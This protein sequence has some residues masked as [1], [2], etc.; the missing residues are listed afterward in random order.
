MKY[1]NLSNFVSL[2]V[3]FL[4]LSINSISAA[5]PNWIELDKLNK[6]T[7]HVFLPNQNVYFDLVTEH[8]IYVEN[9]SWVSSMNKPSFLEEIDLNREIKV[10]LRLKDNTKLYKNNSNHL[11][12]YGKAGAAIPIVKTSNTKKSNVK[13]SKQTTNQSTAELFK[14]KPVV[15][16]VALQH[17]IESNLP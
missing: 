11:K 8:Y 3:F 10:Q 15:N 13:K 7:S 14:Q 9:G 12:M 4:F 17:L 1:S 2:L 6:K 16:D 5:I